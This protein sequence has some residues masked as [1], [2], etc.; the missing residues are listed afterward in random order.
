MSAGD[1]QIED[2]LTSVEGALRNVN[3]KTLWPL[4]VGQITAYFDLIEALDIYN[5]LKELRKNSSVEKIS[6]LL[7][8]PD[9]IRT[10]LTTSAIVGLKVANK[11]GLAK[12]SREDIVD[13]VLF[14]FKILKIKVKSDPFCLDEKNIILKDLEIDKILSE[15]FWDVGHLEECQRKISSLVV[16]LNN[17]CYTLYYDVFK[18]GGFHIHGPYN[19]EKEFGRGAILVVR[20]YHD[21]APDRI[22][23]DL[24][25]SFKKIRIYSVYRNLNFKID[26]F[27][28]PSSLE[29]IGDKLVAFK[30]IVDGKAISHE[31]ADEIIEKITEESKRQASR[32]KQLHDLGKVKKGAEIAFYLFKDFRESMGEHWG[33]PKEIDEMIERFQDRF[34]KEFSCEK[35]TPSVEHLKKVFDPRIDYF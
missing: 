1:N 7:P 29:S 27:N 13:H 26:Y 31:R 28:H 5:K 15:T 23:Q 35:E 2:F 32:V 18:C 9:V 11:M 34:L 8:N 22:W 33:P 30:I 4:C 12:L 10:F 3:Q 20:E 16:S 21:L 17:F 19:A 14:L 25:V 24:K 6:E